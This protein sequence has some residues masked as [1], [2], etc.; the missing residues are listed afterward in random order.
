MCV[1]ANDGSRAPKQE[2]APQVA[3]IIALLYFDGKLTCV[4]R[5]GNQ[6]FSFLALPLLFHQHCWEVVWGGCI[7][8][9]KGTLENYPEKRWEKKENKRWHEKVKFRGFQ[10]ECSLS[11]C[12]VVISVVNSC[13]SIIVSFYSNS[14]S[15]S[16]C[17]SF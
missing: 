15:L 14:L 11:C 17:V 7:E 8:S 5:G 16:V 1:C 12:V 10:N 4:P 6:S 9:N 3:T 2:K 13:W